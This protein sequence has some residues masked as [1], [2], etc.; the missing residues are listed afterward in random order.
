MLALPYPYY[1]KK[2]IYKSYSSFF[3]FS[4]TLPLLHSYSPT[5]NTHIPP[6]FLHR[7]IVLPIL[8]SVHFYTCHHLYRKIPSFQRNL[9]LLQLEN[10]DP[11]GHSVSRCRSVVRCFVTLFR[12][13][14]NLPHHH[15]LC[16]SS[17]LVLVL[18]FGF[19]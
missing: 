3:I 8:A 7:R 2:L 11:E 6:L 16:Y 9:D 14:Q 5:P 12:Q 1:L 19:V 4:V 15:M 18:V 17:A 13:S 10:E